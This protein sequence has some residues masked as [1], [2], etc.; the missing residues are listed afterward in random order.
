MGYSTHGKP[1][2]L[3]LY[4]IDHGVL[5]LP[6]GYLSYLI[7]VLQLHNVAYTIIDDRVTLQPVEFDSRIQFA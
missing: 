2:K 7:R 5:H 1:P 6:R 3:K 4:T